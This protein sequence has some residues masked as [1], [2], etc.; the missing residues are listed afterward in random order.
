MSRTW[1]MVTPMAIA[2]TDHGAVLL[3]NKIYVVGGK[4]GTET[5]NKSVEVYDLDNDIWTPKAPMNKAN[6]NFG[7]R[8]DLIFFNLSVL[9]GH[10]TY[11]T[12][13]FDR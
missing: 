9:N 10:V 3:Q 1:T 13:Y 5:Y 7:V 12:K 6:A 2:R 4:T 8:L 11:F